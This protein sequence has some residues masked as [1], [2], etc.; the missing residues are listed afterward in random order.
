VSKFSE[1]MARDVNQARVFNAFLDFM[2]FYRRP[3]SEILDLVKAMKSR[4]TVDGGTV[5]SIV[6]ALSNIGQPRQAEEVLRLAQRDPSVSV[7]IGTYDILVKAYLKRALSSSLKIAGNETKIKDHPDVSRATQVALELASCAKLDVKFV[8]TFTIAHSR[9]K[10]PQGCLFWVDLAEK[11]SL[12]PL[13][14]LYNCLIESYCRVFNKAAAFACFDRMM[15]SPDKSVLYPNTYTLGVFLRMTAAENKNLTVG[16]MIQLIETLKIAPDVETY[17]VMMW[18]FARNG[19]VVHTDEIFDRMIRSAYKPN[20]SSYNARMVS[21]A[22][23]VGIVPRCDK[24]ISLQSDVVRVRKLFPAGLYEQV[25]SLYKEL[26]KSGEIP[27][28]KSVNTFVACAWVFGDRQHV[29]EAVADIED[30]LQNNSHFRAKQSELKASVAE[31]DGA[32]YDSEYRISSSLILDTTTY[33]MLIS[34]YLECGDYNNAIDVLLNRMP[35]NSVPP[36]DITAYFILRYLST[37]G[38]VV[39]MKRHIDFL[40][41]RRL[42][43]GLAGCLNRDG[44]MLDQELARIRQKVDLDGEIAR[45]ID[46]LRTSR[47]IVNSIEK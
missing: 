44:T 6:R 32:V 16:Q 36:D 43:M 46:W 25:R 15:K 9:L 29:F 34:M 28:V 5:F 10:N 24:L 45:D 23:H 27:S 42:K 40:K 12:K 41:Q 35:R 31:N 2:G 13:T 33:N 22:T 4:S 8:Q 7:D 47:K 19:D 37:N 30:A 18:H 11:L 20:T 3:T 14:P 39:E 21:R 17:N 38:M 26:L 1:L